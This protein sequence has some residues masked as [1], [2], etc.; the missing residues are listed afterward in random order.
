MTFGHEKTSLNI[1]PLHLAAPGNV[2][3]KWQQQ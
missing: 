2:I 3:F 1:S